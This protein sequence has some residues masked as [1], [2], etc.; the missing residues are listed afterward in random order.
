MIFDILPLPI[1]T[2][3]TLKQVPYVTYALC[4]INVFVFMTTIGSSRYE[5][6][7]MV[8]HWG[9]TVSQPSIVTLFTSGFLHTEFLHLA[10]N[11][12]ILWLVGTVLEAGIGSGVFLLFYLAS[13]VCATTLFALISRL[14]FPHSLDIPLI[15]ASGAISGVTGLAAFRYYRVRVMTIPLVSFVIGLLPITL[16]V[17]YKVWIPMWAYAFYFAARELWTGVTEISHHTGTMVAH[18]AHIGGL[19]MG[20]LMALLFQVVQEGRREFA[21][22]DSKKTTRGGGPVP[23]NRSLQELIVLQRQHPNDPEIIEAMAGV[24]MVEQEHEKSRELYLKAL[25]LFLAAGQPERAAINYLNV[26][27]SFPK[28]LMQPREQITLASALETLGHYRE[29]AQ[30]FTLLIDNYPDREEAQTAT[31]RTAQLCQRYL[32]DRVGAERLLKQFIERY[33]LSH[34]KNYAQERLKELTRV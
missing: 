13:L 11:M 16:P 15:G 9:F 30:A 23:A 3:R 33:P 22:E 17:P 1:R 24:L 12:L 21:L 2:D 8:Q 31:L 18:W 28:T 26:L 4:F 20:I 5:T 19:G 32:N 6:S 34:W 27:R 14:F 7:L 25:R 29:A 10:G